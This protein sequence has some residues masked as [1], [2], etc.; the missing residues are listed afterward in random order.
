MMKY[1]IWTVHQLFFHVLRYGGKLISNT[2]A[3]RHNLDPV[4]TIPVCDS[5]GEKS[6]RFQ[7]FT[8][9]P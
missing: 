5:A 4:H 3:N 6:L 9:Y 2:T 8:R 1:A 7:L